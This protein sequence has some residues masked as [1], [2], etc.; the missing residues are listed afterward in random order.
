MEL[1]KFIEGVPTQSDKPLDDVVIADCGLYTPP[2]PA[3]A[4]EAAPAAAEAA[5]AEVEMASAAEAAPAAETP[6]EE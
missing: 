2:P 4:A 5:P 3:P 1:V 6:A